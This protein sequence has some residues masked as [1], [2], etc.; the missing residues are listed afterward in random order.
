MGKGNKKRPLGP[1]FDKNFKKI[2]GKKCTFHHVHTKE[3]DESTTDGL[4]DNKSSE[5]I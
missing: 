5:S 1:N 2:F 3:C 4:E